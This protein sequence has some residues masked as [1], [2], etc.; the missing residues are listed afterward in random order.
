MYLG[1]LISC[2]CL[3]RS[4]LFPHHR[5]GKACSTF[6]GAPHVTSFL[7]QHL[8]FHGN[9]DL[10]LLWE[11]CLWTL[12]SYILISLWTSFLLSLLSSLWI[13]YPALISA[14]PKYS[15][16]PLAGFPTGHW[17]S[18]GHFTPVPEC[19][20][21]HHYTVPSTHLQ[22]TCTSECPNSHCVPIHYFLPSCS[23]Y[24][25]I[26]SLKPVGKEECLSCSGTTYPF[27][28]HAQFSLDPDWSAL[29]TTVRLPL[30]CLISLF[31]IKTFW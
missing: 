9:S 6:T 11:N 28:L 26:P 10:S 16:P 25:S 15:L 20:S 17:L 30:N 5:T 21:G 2:M 29:S 7:G 12:G 22:G 18:F 31:L 19:F 24:G 8:S 14:I 13:F 4:L 23:W 1:K 3:L 27:S